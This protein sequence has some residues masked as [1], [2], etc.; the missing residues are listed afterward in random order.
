MRSNTIR[1]LVE[2]VLGPNA[3]IVRSILFDKTAESNWAVPWHQDLTVA[4]GE[5]RDIPGFVG[6]SVKDGIHHAQA[7]REV[8]EQMLTV[9]LHLDDCGIEN[10]PLRVLPGTHKSGWLDSD[11]INRLKH[12]I[13]EHVC[14]A[15]RGSALVMRPL[16]LHAS[17]R[18]TQPGHR[19][20]LHIDFAAEN[21]F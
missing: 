4:V 2:R 18:A 8:L 21:A 16:L 3:F 12:E 13:P 6:W 20:V 10:G 1:D 9:R 19:R 7:P 11:T 14:V 5:R 15:S 17:S